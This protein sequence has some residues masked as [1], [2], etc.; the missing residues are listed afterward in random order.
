MNVDLTHGS[1][2]RGLLRFSLPLMAG[3]LLQQLYNLV[4]T[5]VVGRYCGEIALAAVGSAFSVMILLTSIV[6]GLCMG[7]GVVVSQLFGQKDDAGVRKAVGNA[8]VLIAG[9]SALLTVLS[10]ALLP[11]MMALL[12]IPPE[13]QGDL[14][15]YLLIVF[16]GIIPTFLYNF[17]ACMLRAVGNS[18]APLIFLLI[19]S[20]T[21]VALDFLFV[22]ALPWG[23]AGAAVATLI[24][25]VLSG[26]LCLG[27]VLFRVP[28][29][30]PSQHDLR[31]D[32]ALFGRIFS[33]SAMT[34]IQQSIMNFGILCV[35]SL[36][37]SF[38]LAAMAAFTAGV[39]IDS[40]AYSPAQDFGN[41]FATFVAQNQGANQPQRL[42]HGI[43]SAFL[44]SGGFCLIVSALVAIFAE[45]LLLVFLKNASAESFHRHNVPSHRG[46]V[47]HRHRFPVPALRHFPRFGAGRHE[48]RPDS[49]F[50]WAAR[51][52][53][54]RLRAAFR[55]DGDLAGNSGRLA[56]CGYRRFRCHGAARA[57]A[58]RFQQNGQKCL[59]TAGWI[60]RFVTS[61]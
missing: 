25:Q 3:N 56:D 28:A 40:L 48:H 29:L 59:M 47:L 9:V 34:S 41:G 42:R 37:N 43:R 16:I 52:A 36:V 17:G 8:F 26:F 7:S 15:C 22:A 11:V 49:A 30:T 61:L 10:Y 45:P 58:F 2:F 55:H 13:A 1:I 50:A 12:R 23:V 44:L 33:V 20:L 24:S 18:T 38:G 57:N 14:S 53:V 32:R 35:Q 6:T 5:F 27:Y 54:L 39:K 60:R 4:D 46:A 19:S 51:R 21:N 31:P